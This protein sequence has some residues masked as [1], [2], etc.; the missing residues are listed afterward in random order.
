MAEGAVYMTVT[1]KEDRPAAVTRTRYVGVLPDKDW[2]DGPR[3]G[4]SIQLRPSRNTPPRPPSQGC[5]ARMF[6]CWRPPPDPTE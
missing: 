2:A 6:R 3:P 1:T 4:V 5:V